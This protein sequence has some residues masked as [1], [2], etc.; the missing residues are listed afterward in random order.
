MEARR[1][2]LEEFVPFTV[3]LAASMFL[4]AELTSFVVVFCVHSICS[5]ASGEVAACQL[6]QRNPPPLEYLAAAKASR[7]SFEGGVPSMDQAALGWRFGFGFE[8]F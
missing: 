5:G 2:T 8:P 3:L 6:A 4:C 1:T 7:Q